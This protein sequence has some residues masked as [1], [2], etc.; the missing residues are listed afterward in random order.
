MDNDNEV[1]NNNEVINNNEMEDNDNDVEENYK[2]MS[3]KI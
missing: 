2:N 1:V 3:I